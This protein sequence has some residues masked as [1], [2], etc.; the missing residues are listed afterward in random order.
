M[1]G[2]LRQSKA[3]RTEQRARSGSGSGASAQREA[4]AFGNLIQRSGTAE[5][6]GGTQ[7]GGEP[8]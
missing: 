6:G 3:R 8:A 5:I 4:N 2:G 7:V 1:Q